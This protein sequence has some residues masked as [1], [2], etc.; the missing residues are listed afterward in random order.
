MRLRK[1]L[2]L[3]FVNDAKNCSLFV[4]RIFCEFCGANCYQKSKEKCRINFDFLVY[5]DT[6]H[7]DCLNSSN[8]KDIYGFTKKNTFNK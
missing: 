4:I 3:R 8:S 7:L 1:D 6:S 2:K 5:N